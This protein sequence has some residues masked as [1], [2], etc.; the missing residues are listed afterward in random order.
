MQIW[1]WVWNLA[2]RYG[3]QSKSWK[4]FCRRTQIWDI[5]AQFEIVALTKIPECICNGIMKSVKQHSTFGVLNFNCWILN[6]NLRR[7]I[8]ISILRFLPY[9]ENSDSQIMWCAVS[10]IKTRCKSQLKTP[11]WRAHSALDQTRILCSF[12]DLCHHWSLEYWLKD[13]SFCFLCVEASLNLI[14]SSSSMYK[15]TD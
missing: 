13:E 15:I 11:A 2:L 6:Q 10:Y 14:V 7:D 8:F 3:L 9:N 12:L 4:W 1:V 5:N